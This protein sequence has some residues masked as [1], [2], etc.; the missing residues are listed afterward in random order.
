MPH[1]ENTSQHYDEG[2][3]PAA[4]DLDLDGEG[5]DSIDGG[6][7]NAGQHGRIV[8]EQK[9]KGNAVFAPPVGKAGYAVFKKFLKFDRIALK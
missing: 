3:A 5:F 6:G 9:R 8:V 2:I 7:Q 4:I 1:P